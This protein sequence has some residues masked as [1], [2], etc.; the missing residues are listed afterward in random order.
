MKVDALWMTSP[1]KVEVRQVEV[2]DP[3]FNEIQ[4]EVKANGICKWDQSLYKGLS[5]V[6]DFPFTFGH[7]PAGV[8]T[9]VGRGVQGF[10]VGDNV[11][12][13]GG[14]DSM[15]QVVNIPEH[16]AAVINDPVDDYALWVGEPVSC[17]VNSMAHVPIAPGDDVMLIGTGYMG[18]V[19]IQA[20]NRTLR[21]RLVCF[22]LDDRRIALAKEF[23]AD[24][25]YNVNSDEA[26]K[27]IEQII[28]SGGMD[29][30]I[31]CSGEESGYELALK[32]LKQAGTLELYGWQRGNRTFDGS[33]WHLG[34][35]KIINSAPNIE[36][37]YAPQR[38]AQTV[39]LI[40]SGVFDQSKL[41]THRTNYKHAA[42]AIE[43]AIEK[44]DGYIKGVMT[45]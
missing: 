22:E 11:M 28:E 45:F 26:K 8:V 27:R 39:K 21:G 34:G 41:I 31:E 20:L 5:L 16:C 19:K 25:V 32:C 4:I 24:E 2:G 13:C 38:V 15:V 29:L 9:K 40:S 17:V 43:R 42:E 44:A 7:E 30:V 14:N 3:E 37:F 18:L 35:I 36:K 10:K 6:T 23:G 33:P 12:C 1:K